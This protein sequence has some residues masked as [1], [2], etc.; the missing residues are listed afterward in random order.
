MNQDAERLAALLDGWLAGEAAEPSAVEEAELLSV[1]AQVRALEAVPPPP[2]GLR[3][4]RALFLSAGVAQAQDRSR[5][6]WPGP[7]ELLRRGA[8]QRLAPL[9]LGITL[10]M[11]VG[12]ATTVQAQASLPGD[13]LY[14][15]KRLTENVQVTIARGEDRESLQAELE[16][17]RRWEAQA[18]LEQRRAVAVEFE[19]RVT[20]LAAGRL[21][22]DGLV[23]A[24]DDLA[25]LVGLAPGAVV[26]VVGV[27]GTDGLL[28]AE[29]VEV[30]EPPEDPVA[31]LNVEATEVSRLVASDERPEPTSTR[32]ATE[33]RP[34]IV[35]TRQVSPTSFAPAVPTLTPVP[36]APPTAVPEGPPLRERQ[37]VEWTGYLEQMGPEWWVVGGQEVYRPSGR[38]AGDAR[39]GA[40]VWVKAERKH[41]ALYLVELRVL[42]P[43]PDPEVVEWRGTIQAI[44]GELWTVDGQAVLVTEE[45]EVIGAPEIGRVARVRALLYPDGRRVALRIEV[46]APRVVE[47]SGVL[48][49][50]E[51]EAW[52]VGGRVVRLVPGV[53]EIRGTPW[54]GARVD[55]RARQAE[56]GQ[57]E[58]LV[59]VV[60][61]AA[62][63][64]T[65]EPTPAAIEPG[66][67]ATLVSRPGPTAMP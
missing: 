25:G 64:P 14:A 57:L 62:P 42:N 44:D 47:F 35:P 55:V 21:T 66:P 52:L 15:V 50:M 8:R 65:T 12:A 18:L 41:G 60:R 58:A 2:G 10:A 22:V 63:T 48:E 11:T 51:L 20:L 40:L 49:S 34:G 43:A 6:G 28:Y 39:L 30:L 38:V 45:A 16:A 54:V 33:V 17:R 31:A 4:G 56:D 46:E 24:F 27:T 13:A 32:R 19:G 7:L 67:A 37:T 1:A 61:D 36:T 23:V 59:L 53:T 9:T 3:R 5:A 29:R 26:R